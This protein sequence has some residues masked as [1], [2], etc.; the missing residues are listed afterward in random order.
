VTANPLFDFAIGGVDEELAA[1]DSNCIDDWA[2]RAYGNS[3]T[4][5]CRSP[6]L[7]FGTG[8][9]S[10]G[11]FTTFPHARSAESSRSRDTVSESRVPVYVAHVLFEFV[12]YPFVADRLSAHSRH[13]ILKG[14]RSLGGVEAV[15]NVP[16]PEE[17]TGL[18]ESRDP[19]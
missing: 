13:P 9:T 15:H 1:G 3:D 18:Q 19:S 12:A 5:D 14:L 2:E 8:Y 17:T 10:L 4:I 16:Q 6:A 7:S 11:R